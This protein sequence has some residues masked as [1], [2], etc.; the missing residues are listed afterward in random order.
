MHFSTGN[1]LA[2]DP[3]STYRYLLIS[4]QLVVAS[5]GRFALK[6]LTSRQTPESKNI[7]RAMALIMISPC[8]AIATRCYASMSAYGFRYP[9]T[10]VAM[11]LCS[12]MSVTRCISY[13]TVGQI[14]ARTKALLPRILEDN[15]NYSLL[16]PASRGALGY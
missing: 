16:L 7:L 13:A 10:F 9:Y 15:Y 2:R 6:S 4:I 3:I 12:P 14:N 8:V 5:L 1:W 11:F